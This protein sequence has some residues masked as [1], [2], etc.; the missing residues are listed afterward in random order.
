MDSIRILTSEI[1]STINRGKTILVTFLDI[2]SIFDCDSKPTTW[3][4]EGFGCT[5]FPTQM[6]LLADKKKRSLFYIAWCSKLFSLE[7]LY[8]VSLKVQF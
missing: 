5:F 8:W 7:F 2:S 4:V 6:L 3:K 1:Q